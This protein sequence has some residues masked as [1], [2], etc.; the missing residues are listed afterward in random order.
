VCT[1]GPAP[2]PSCMARAAARSASAACGP[3]SCARW[4]TPSAAAAAARRH[5]AAGRGISVLPEST[6][7]YYRRPDVAYA[8][9]TDIAPT[10]V[11]LAWVS[12]RRSPLI[13][14]FAA[15]ATAD[16]QASTAARA[17]EVTVATA[18]TAS[19]QAGLPSA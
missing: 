8:R 4:M 11:G 12:A 14:E 18:V 7:A 10:A 2:T 16:A 17:S 6:A 19:G 9:I 3:P 1:Y 15:L 5:V 13:A